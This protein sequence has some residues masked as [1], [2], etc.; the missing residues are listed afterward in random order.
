MFFEQT[1]LSKS[2]SGFSAERGVLKKVQKGCSLRASVAVFLL[3]FLLCECFDIQ[4]D[5]VWGGLEGNKV[6]EKELKEKRLKAKRPGK[7]PNQ[8][9]I[10]I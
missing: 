10:F 2:G 1:V 7:P 8:L 9:F 4:G 3:I 6:L 5:V